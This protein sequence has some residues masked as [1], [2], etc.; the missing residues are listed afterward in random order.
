[1]VLELEAKGDANAPLA[2]EAATMC[3]VRTLPRRWSSTSPSGGRVCQALVE[4]ARHR[5][6]HCSGLPAAVEGAGRR[7]AISA[8]RVRHANRQPVLTR[9]R[10]LLWMMARDK[11][12]RGASE[13]SLP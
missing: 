4:R 10:T 12:T 1:M 13:I 7:W 8:A 5:P 3:A 9:Y 6:D 2:S 11:A